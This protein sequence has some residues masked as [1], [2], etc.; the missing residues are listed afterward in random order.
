MVVRV[1]LHACVPAAVSVCVYVSVPVYP[2]RLCMYLCVSLYAYIP[3]AVSVYISVHVSL[4][5]Y[6]CSC[7]WMGPLSR[8]ACMPAAFAVC[9]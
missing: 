4:C 8:Y 5:V 2:L 6:T 1:P 3:A 7:A 9:V